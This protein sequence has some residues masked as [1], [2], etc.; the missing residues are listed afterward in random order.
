MNVPVGGD[1]SSS[2]F[3][4]TNPGRENAR[5]QPSSKTEA[6]TAVSAPT[7]QVIM[8]KVGWLKA[9]SVNRMIV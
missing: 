4:V 7:A 2:C 5:R 8:A 6:F 3:S 9:V 1:F